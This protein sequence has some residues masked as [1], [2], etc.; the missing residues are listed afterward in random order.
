MGRYLDASECSRLLDAARSLGLRHFAS[1]LVMLTTGIR[2]SELSQAQWRH[3]FRDPEGRLGLLVNGKGG[4]QRVVRI[5]DDVFA[6]LSELHSSDAL[7]A[8][9]QS[10]LLPSSLGKPYSDRGIRKMVYQAVATSGISKA[11]SPH[12][13]RH[14]N[15]TLAASNGAPVYVIQQSLGHA[16]INTSQRYIHWA[17]GLADTTTDYIPA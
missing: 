3:L 14:T 10:P 12:W 1:I 2:I 15:A 9:D 17:R 5:R 16:S 8:S 4:K 13:L 7:S 11:V 6:V